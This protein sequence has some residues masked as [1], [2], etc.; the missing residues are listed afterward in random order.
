MSVCVL[1]LCYDTS[2]YF[3]PNSPSFSCN[4]DFSAHFFKK[5]IYF[6]FLEN[7]KINFRKVIYSF[8]TILALLRAGR[9]QS[10]IVLTRSEDPLV[11]SI[12]RQKFIKLWTMIQC[13]EFE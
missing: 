1:Y 13:C 8:K 10:M 11:W 7:L 9:T 12:G 5:Q 6:T 4:C 3:F 2:F